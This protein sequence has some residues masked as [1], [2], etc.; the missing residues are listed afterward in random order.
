MEDNMTI[1]DA[2][3]AYKYLNDAVRGDIEAEAWTKAL[4]YT[5]DEIVETLEEADDSDDSRFAWD[6]ITFEFSQEKIDGRDELVPLGGV[7]PNEESDVYDAAHEVGWNVVEY[8]RREVMSLQESTTYSPREFV[9]LVLHAAENVPE[10]VAHREMDISLGNYR[11][12]VGKVNEKHESA[13][14]T[15][16]LTDR[17]RAN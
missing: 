14:K 13:E 3:L 8:I 4:D 15:V 16:S 17:L 7:E 11:G 1:A 5:D 6:G 10:D 9:A 12:K 2:E